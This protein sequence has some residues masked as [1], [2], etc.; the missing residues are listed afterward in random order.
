MEITAIMS[1]E[2]TD[3]VTCIIKKGD[4]E[5]IRKVISYEDYAKSVIGV[6]GE[7]RVCRV[8]QLPRGF[9]DG[10]ANERCIEALI[11]VPAGKRR[12]SYLGEEYLIPFPEIF[13]HFL[14]DSDGTVKG[15][16]CACKMG[17]DLYHYPFGNVYEEGRICWGGNVLPKVNCL[18]QFDL[19]VELFFS[20]TTNNDLYSGPVVM[21]EGKAYRLS[22]RELIEHLQGVN[23]FPKEWLRPLNL[24]INEF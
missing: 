11:S 19:L 4:G 15:T 22:Q 1:S 6:L 3:E 8:G 10:G 2:R 14:A 7:D 24:P 18:K 23:E 5:E 13:F 21:K 16:K 20:A 12:F 9:V 17:D